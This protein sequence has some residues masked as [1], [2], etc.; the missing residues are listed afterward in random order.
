[1]NEEIWK[2]IIG[3]EGYYQVSNK[4]SVRS[5]D[6][7]VP[8]V[9]NVTSFHLKKRKGRELSLCTTKSGYC[10]AGLYKDGKGVHHS[11]HRL[12]AKHFLPQ[13]AET[14][15]HKDGNKTNNCVENLEWCSQK[16]NTIHRSKVL[17]KAR[18][19]KQ[20]LSKL[21]EEQV[22]EIF[23]RLSKGEATR[24]LARDYGVSA[25][26]LHSIKIGESWSWLT[27]I[28]QRFRDEEK[29]LEAQN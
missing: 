28:Q 17:G 27:G 14:V 15:N 21:T 24:K 19:Q 29:R 6:R 25:S 11:V 18:G 8:L 16:E 20:H 26:S 12:V 4:G 5:L 22:L 7:E 13:T 9:S 3:Y 23:S 10:T 1:M 2:D